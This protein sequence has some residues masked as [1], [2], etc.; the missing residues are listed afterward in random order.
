VFESAISIVPKGVRFT[1]ATLGGVPGEWAETEKQAGNGTLLYLHGGGYVS[2]SARLYRP[3][4]GEFALRGLRVF[5]AD[6]RL[7]P[8]HT[9]P[10]ALDDATAAWRALRTKVEGPTVEALRAV[11]HNTVEHSGR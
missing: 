7:A 4:T 5:A 3:I 2:M 1:Q 10:A 9:F 6:Y 8:E 11:T